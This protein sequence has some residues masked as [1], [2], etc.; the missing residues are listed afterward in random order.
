MTPSAPVALMCDYAGVLTTSMYGAAQ[1]VC[2]ELGVDYPH[3]RAALR[4]LRDVDDPVERIERGELVREEFLKHFHVQLTA[5]LGGVDGER[6][7]D[8]MGE[9]IQ[10]EPRMNAAVAQLR[11]AGVPVALVSNSWGNE[12]PPEVLARFDV[13]VVSG[14]V[15]MRKPDPEIFELAAKQ[16]GVEPA[17][18]V[19]VDDFEVNTAGAAALGIRTILHEDV[20]ATLRQL[21]AWFGVPLDV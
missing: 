21:S 9:L 16:L 20:D 15:G 3:F 19:F 14:E 18:C 12:Y 13:V 6:F 5:A 17:Q 4:A 11:A 8:R 10:P 2:A 1:Q 7:L